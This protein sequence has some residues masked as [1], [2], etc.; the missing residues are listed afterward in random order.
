LTFSVQ[1]V[2]REENRCFHTSH[3][4]CY[5]GSVHRSWKIKY[6]LAASVA[7]LTILV[8]LPALFNGFVEWDDTRYVIDNPDI[9]TF[10]ASFFRWAFFGFHVSNWHPLT[11]VSH[12]LDYAV[13]GLNPLGHHLTNILLHAIN[14]ALVVLLIG[15][16][17]EISRERLAQN[18][19]APF[20]SD[21]TVLIAAG[22]TG[23]LFGIH[24]V[25]VESVAWVAERKDLLCALFFLLSIIMY[26]THMV[27]H[28]AG[29]GDREV[30]SEAW[31]STISNR[32][33]TIRRYYILSIAFFIL[34]LMSKPMAVSL[35]V[36]LLI[37]DWYPF[38]RIRSFKTFW[39][40]IVEKLPFIILSLASSIVA[41]IAQKSEGALSLTDKVPLSVRI[42]VAAKAVV[43]YLGKML[44]PV[45]LVPFYPYP[46]DVSLFTFGYIFAIGLVVVLTT[47]CVVLVRRQK[48]W[49]S[50]W[51]YYVVTL[52]P[53]L[54]IIQVGGQAMADR[55]TYLPSLGPFLIIGLIS[56]RVAM[57]IRKRW[58]KN[59]YL[60]L[61]TVSLILVSTL[62][63]VTVGQIRIWHD[64]IA[65]WNYELGKMPDS[66]L[67]YV[68]RGVAFTK[69]GQFDKAIEDY[70][71]AISRKPSNPK[72]FFNRGVL[73]A[74]L[75]L[76]SQ[77]IIDYSSAI[78]LKPSYYEA[79]N[80][81]GVL[82]ER[83]GQLDKAMAD[84][85]MAISLDPSNDQAYINR[86]R[87][88]DRIGQPEHALADF[89][90]AVFLSPDDPDA[91][92]NRG[93]FFSKTGK[94]DRALTDLDRSIYLNPN[95]PDAYYNRGQVLQRSGQADQAARDFLI[96]KEYSA[97]R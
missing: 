2:E 73:L 19:S 37:L 72:A 44:V 61:G 20:L 40:S 92:Y 90:R 89:D 60:I 47:A 11:W 24:P 21:R 43:A 4:N 26:V 78:K 46:G 77:A 22:V 48:L 54:G 36:V 68:N 79:Y 25:H 86:G 7:L 55:Y 58:E 67:A 29:I 14:T 82:Y 88:Y 10:N 8:Y 95:D 30:G 75:N 32:Q 80:N 34:A 64:S 18:S 81:R 38:G 53:V 33:P 13:W 84:Y 31:Q 87:V 27:I 59:G 42:P 41:V 76:V 51:G 83:L 74:K 66:N 52:I 23:L 93:L 69:L 57:K 15:K 39:T 6:C 65:F 71:E 62:T 49:L 50:A 96:W 97:K 9:R 3:E 5:G 1:K 70:T 12:A 85:G 63:Y 35:P 28:G 16:L 45:N 56:A 94:L 17:L 91:Y